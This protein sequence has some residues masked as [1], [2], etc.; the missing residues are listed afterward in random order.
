MQGKMEWRGTGGLVGS[1]MGFLKSLFKHRKPCHAELMG[2]LTP[3][4]KMFWLPFYR[5]TL[6]L[7]QER[8]ALDPS[9]PEAQ[10]FSEL[11]E[12]LIVQ[13]DPAVL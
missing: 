7:R 9:I 11:V 3:L 12:I 13:D 10:Q 1:R 4:V 5:L 2:L 8:R 6:I